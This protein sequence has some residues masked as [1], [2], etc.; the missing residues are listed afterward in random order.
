L[1][2]VLGIGRNA[3]QAEIKNA[4]RRMAKLLHPDVNR[5]PDAHTQFI[6]LQEA[7]D[8][9]SDPGKCARYEAGLALE[10]SLPPASANDQMDE[11]AYRSPLRCG[12]ILAEGSESVSGFVAS[13]IIQWSDIVVNGKTLVVSWPMGASEFTEEW[14]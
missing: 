6:H 10:A 2:G 13:K 1:F 4:Y 5:E 12:Y 14:I 8:I 3:G 9:L 11:N 7:Y